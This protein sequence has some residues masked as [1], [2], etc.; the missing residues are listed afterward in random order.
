MR[1]AYANAKYVKN[2]TRGRN[3]HIGQFIAGAVAR[4]HEIWAWPGTEHPDVKLIPSG[5]VERTLALRKMDILYI[6]L[7]ATPAAACFYAL[8]P[9]RQ[10]Y[11]S[12]LMVWEFNTVPEFNLLMGNSQAQVEKT[13]QTLRRLG[14]GCDLAVCVSSA[15]A[16]YAR[17]TLQIRNTLTVPN[18]SDPQLF[19]P[20]AVPVRRVERLPGRLNVAWIGSA[21]LSWHNFELMRQAAEKLWQPGEGERVAFHIIG[22]QFRM[23]RDMPPNIHYY[24]ADDYEA[25]PHWLA[26]MDVGLCLYHPGPADYNSPLKLFDYMSSG[27]AVVATPQPQVVEVF[28]Q[29]GQPDLLVQPDDPSALAG[30]LLKLAEDRERVRGLG[31]SGRQLVV[32]YY[33]WD[34]VVDDTF[35]AIQKL[36]ASRRSPHTSQKAFSLSEPLDKRMDSR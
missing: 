33:N 28:E 1:L 11:G 8:P 19:H 24:G 29:L 17:E 5:R 31:Q 34:R 10:I 14:Q 18:G 21:E 27:L 32:D 7:Q 26:A 15:I 35:Y 25:I 4:G 12:P 16:Q 30:L 23:M 20:E 13:I 3:A 2:D 6:R 22:Q 36:L 9:Q